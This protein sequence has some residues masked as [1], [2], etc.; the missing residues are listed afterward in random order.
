MPL[1][2]FAFSRAG[3]KQW[4]LKKQE[5]GLSQKKFTHHLA[6]AQGVLLVR[7]T[8]FQPDCALL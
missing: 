5:F 2:W 6:T 1:L 7:E 8:P 4:R 3:S